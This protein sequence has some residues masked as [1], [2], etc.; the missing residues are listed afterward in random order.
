M[1]KK[2]IDIY[3]LIFLFLFLFTVDYSFLDSLVVKFLESDEEAFVSRIVDGDTIIGNNESIRLLGINTP[4]RKE[5][6][7]SE[8]K[9]FLEKEILNKTVQLKFGKERKDL[10]NRTLAYIFLNGENVNLGVVE[11]GF[12]NYY[13]PA[14]KDVYYDNFQEAWNECL[15]KNINLCEKSKDICS[16]CVELKNFDYKNEIVVFGNKCDFSCDLTNWEIKDE[17][18][19]KFIFLK[20]VLNGNKEITI[21]VGNETGKENVLFWKNEN[22]VW[23]RTGDTLFLRDEEGKLVLW[24][25]Y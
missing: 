17:G 23:T 21:K 22:Y 10:Y 18:R 2:R 12:G 7:Y 13:F 11:N 14:G 4:E 3:L 9:E 6:Y 19:K 5:K 16:S 25:S 1:S 20:F 15:K 8:A 24:K